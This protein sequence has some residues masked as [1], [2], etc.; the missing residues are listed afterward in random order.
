MLL[1][2]NHLAYCDTVIKDMLLDQIGA[3]DAADR[4][5]TVAGPKVYETPFRRMAS[6]DRY[7]QDS[8]VDN[9]HAQSDRT[10]AQAGREIAVGTMRAAHTLM[11][12]VG[13]YSM[14]RVQEQRSTAGLIHQGDSK[15]R[16]GTRCSPHSR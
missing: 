8:T 1:L 12:R 13:S 9:N 3:T 6:R 10:H 4:L 15:V 16:E 11:V 2:C 5:T 7:P 14:E